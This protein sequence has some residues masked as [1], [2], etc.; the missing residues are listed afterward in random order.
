LFSKSK[1]L[2]S[3]QK[4][5]SKNSFIFQFWW[6]STWM[7]GWKGTCKEKQKTRGWGG[8]SSWGIMLIFLHD[9]KVAKGLTNLVGAK[10]MPCLRKFE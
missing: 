5:K 3:S 8:L 6:T 1:N 7:E 10:K 9:A 2:L 4:S